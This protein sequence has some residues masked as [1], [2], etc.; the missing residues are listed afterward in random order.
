MSQNTY[1]YTL[2]FE[3]WK[4]LVRIKTLWEDVGRKGRRLDPRFLLYAS[5]RIGSLF[6]K[7]GG[8]AKDMRY[9]M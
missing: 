1:Y 9:G 3:N 8:G 5:T 4:K 7:R 6:A 2:G